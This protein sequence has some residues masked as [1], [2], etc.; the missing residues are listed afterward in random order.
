MCSSSLQRSLECRKYI[1]LEYRRV[2][3]QDRNSHGSWKMADS[4]RQEIGNTSRIYIKTSIR[5]I[6]ISKYSYIDHC[7]GSVE[8]KRRKWQQMRSSKC[9]HSQSG[10]CMLLYVYLQ[11]IFSVVTLVT[12][13]W[14]WIIMSIRSWFSWYRRVYKTCLT[15]NWAR[16]T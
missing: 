7:R 2:R 9:E 10:N 3:P 6:S 16:I 1:S 4:S 8:T 13:Y 15:I 5:R 14:P 11:H 12:L